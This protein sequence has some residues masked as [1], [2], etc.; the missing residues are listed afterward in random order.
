[1][2][3]YAGPDARRVS[4]LPPAPRAIARAAS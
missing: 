4:G 1:V 2:Y 3:L